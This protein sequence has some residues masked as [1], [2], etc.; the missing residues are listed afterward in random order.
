MD[1]SRTWK[2]WTTVQQDLTSNSERKI[3]FA[4]KK[5]DLQADNELARFV[6]TKVK[7]GSKLSGQEKETFVEGIQKRR[8]K[9]HWKDLTR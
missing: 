1:W 5:L 8:Q 3:A 6:E 9:M 4:Y 7:G 2:I